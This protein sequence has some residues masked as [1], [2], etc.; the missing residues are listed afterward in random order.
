MSLLNRN[1]D[2]GKP[3]PKPQP[4]P[5]APDGQPDPVRVE[6]ERTLEPPKEIPEPTRQT[7]EKHAPPGQKGFSVGEGITKVTV[8][9]VRPD[10]SWV[11]DTGYVVPSKH[12]T[13]AKLA[14]IRKQL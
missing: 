10:G 11:L 1:K 2:A 3:R 12:R 6:L 14:Q 13:P 4:R 9:E 8:V 7:V 5:E